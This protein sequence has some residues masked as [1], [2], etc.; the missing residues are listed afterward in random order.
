M[1]NPGWYQTILNFF[2]ALMLL[3]AVCQKS[4]SAIETYRDPLTGMEFVFIKGGC[5]Q[6]GDQFSDGEPDEKPV[7]RV[8][9]DDFYLG[10]YEVTQAQ[11]EKIMGNNPSAINIG[12]DYPVDWISWD[13]AQLFLSRMTEYSKGRFRLP[14]EAEWE[15]ACRARGKTVRYG[16]KDGTFSS[17]LANS[18][19]GR[20]EEGDKSDG[21]LHTSPVGFYPPNKLGLYD[22]SGNV[23]EWMSD[24]RDMNFSYYEISPV[25]NPQ[26]PDTGIRRVGRGGAWNFGPAHLRCSNRFS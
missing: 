15:Y 18:G 1:K 4:V 17:Q 8:C 25:N 10:R 3:Q 19:S 22:M 24:W 26:G 6:M 7:H 23:W 14:T 9:V 11:W 12:A 5:Y 13:E 2:L 16:T 21:H 20:W